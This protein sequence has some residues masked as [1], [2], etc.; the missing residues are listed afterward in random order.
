MLALLM[1]QL[2]DDERAFMLDLYKNHYGLVRKNIYRITHSY[3][4]IEDLLNE[5][6]IK[7]IEK[8]ST[9]CTF[10]CCRLAS[11]IVYTSKSVAINYL[12]HK[13]IENKHLYYSDIM[14]LIGED[15]KVPENSSEE[16]YLRQEDIQM[17]R[18]VVIRL[19][20]QQKDLLYYKYILEMSDEEISK[21]LG[22]AANSVRQYLT[23]AR[24]N[25]KSLIEKEA[26][27][28]VK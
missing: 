5:V 12:K 20:Q 27:K 14:D 18:D 11:Y 22:I 3:D 15:V 19:P 16:R 9:L 24:R 26:A 1:M 6:F 21:I 23:R 2:E 28:D 17:L 4:E 7:L 8:I 25:A 10:D 13:S